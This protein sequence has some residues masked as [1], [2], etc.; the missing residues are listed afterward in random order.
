MPY[1]KIKS[2]RV[3]VT[4]T[5]YI[6]GKKLKKVF[7]QMGPR[8]SVN[9]EEPTVSHKTVSGPKPEEIPMVASVPCAR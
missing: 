1:K 5:R 4:C 9:L 3:G 2:K 7:V 6:A 8:P